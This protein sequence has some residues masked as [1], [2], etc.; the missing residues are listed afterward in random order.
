MQNLVG[1]LQGRSAGRRRRGIDM[2]LLPQWPDDGL[3]CIAAY[4]Q[5]K[6]ITIEQKWSGETVLIP[7]NR[8][9]PHKAAKE[10]WVQ[11]NWSE[12]TACTVT[13]ASGLDKQ[14]C[15]AND[16]VDHVKKDDSGTG[17]EQGIS[18]AQAYRRLGHLEEMAATVGDGKRLPAQD[19]EVVAPNTLVT[20]T[21]AKKRKTEAEEEAGPDTSEKEKAGEQHEKGEE[22]SKGT[23]QGAGG[24]F[25]E[26]E[27]EVPQP[28]AGA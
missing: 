1:E 10:L 24:L 8:L 21:P 3:F 11:N 7:I 22:E 12:T 17:C 23:G 2:P 4:A 28:P 20:T 27:L 5:E 16:F 19:E 15:L 26:A 6:G 14:Y 9:P 18:K 13:D 25:D